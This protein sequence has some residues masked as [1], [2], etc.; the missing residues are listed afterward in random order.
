M[1]KLN[2]KYLPAPRFFYSFH[3]AQYHAK[4]LGISKRNYSITLEFYRDN[5]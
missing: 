1:Y 3:D 2:S 4:I 5:I